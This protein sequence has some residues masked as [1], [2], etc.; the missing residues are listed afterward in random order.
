M[1]I[2]T[3]IS[4]AGFPAHATT[5]TTT[6]TTAA[7][8]ALLTA[9]FSTPRNGIVRLSHVPPLRYCYNCVHIFICGYLSPFFFFFSE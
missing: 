1:Y 4:S 7:A 2:Y 8:V 3:C 6:T 9:S 5:A